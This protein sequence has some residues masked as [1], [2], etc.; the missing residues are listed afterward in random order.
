MQTLTLRVLVAT[1]PLILLMTIA[2]LSETIKRHHSRRTV[3]RIAS[4]AL[5]GLAQGPLMRG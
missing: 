4:G 2:I 3:K 5:K 1:T